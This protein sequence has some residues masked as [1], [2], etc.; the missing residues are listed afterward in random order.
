MNFNH[1]LSERQKKHRCKG[2]KQECYWVP[3][4]NIRSMVGEHVNVSLAC[5]HCGRREELFL[6]TREFKMQE[7][8]ITSEVKREQERV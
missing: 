3:T 7:R 8:L 4:G 6:T 5:R 2:A 1:L